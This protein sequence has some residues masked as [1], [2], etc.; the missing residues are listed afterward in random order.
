MG[1][2]VDGV[3]ELLQPFGHIPVQAGVGSEV[4]KPDTHE[5]C[6]TCL[7]VRLAP[8]RRK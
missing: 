3:R 1:K 8:H 6:P 7:L 5:L 4:G 2:F